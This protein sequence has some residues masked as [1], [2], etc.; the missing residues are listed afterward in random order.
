MRKYRTLCNTLECIFDTAV[1]Y[2]EEEVR[3]NLLKDLE[4]QLFR[5]ALA[6]DLE[7]ALDDTDLSWRMLLDE[8]D[9]GYFESEEEAKQFVIENI[10][11]PTL[12]AQAKFGSAKP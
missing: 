12:K 9:V 1:G 7:G 4:Y 11:E 3:L 8:Y 2:T 5:D 10:V 6:K